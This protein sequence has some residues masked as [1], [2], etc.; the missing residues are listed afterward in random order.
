MRKE[1]LGE[2]QHCFLLPGRAAAAA[3]IRPD[4]SF[5]RKERKEGT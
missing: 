3:A 1:Q 4:F 2:H 5:K